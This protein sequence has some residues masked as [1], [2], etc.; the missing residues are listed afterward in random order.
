MSISLECINVFIN[1]KLITD[2]NCDNGNSNDD[3][4]VNELVRL[5]I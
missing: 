1:S 3:D 2:L 4:D 5:F